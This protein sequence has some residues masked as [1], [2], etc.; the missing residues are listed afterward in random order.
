M[1]NLFLAIVVM[2]FT[3]PIFAQ[4]GIVKVTITGIENT[5]GNVVIG[6]YNSKSTFPVFGK[7]MQGAK[8]KPT[9]TGS[10]NYTFENLPD[11]TYAI[12]VWH[13]ENDNQEMDKNIFGAP[14]ENYGFSKNIF[15]TFGPPDYEE[16]L[17]EVKNGKIVK[18]T[19]NLE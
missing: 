16:V 10:L 7:E 15:G 8:I 2:V 18:L 13:D 17:F 1:K 11:G 3:L 12:A 14:K 6:I 5:D 4:S 9:K 19:I